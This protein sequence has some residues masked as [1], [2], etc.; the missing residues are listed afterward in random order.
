[1]NTRLPMTPGRVLAL[2]IG[3]PLALVVIGWTALTA[4]AYAGIG[5]YPV[6]LDLPVR[7]HTVAVAIDS[8]TMTV[9]QITGDRLRVTGTARYSLVRSTVTRRITPAGVTVSAGCHFVTGVC[10]FTAQVGLPAGVQASLSNA[11]GDMTLR[12]LASRVDVVAG[13]GDV[14]PYDLSGPVSIQ[15]NSGDVT[16]AGLSGPQVVVKSGSGDIVIGGLTSADV[17]ASNAS[18]DVVLTF[19]KVPDRVSVSASSGDVRLQLPPGP[20]S[21]QV[22][23]STS[24]GNRAVNVPVSSA[25]PH[26]IIVTDGS[27]D[28]SIT[29]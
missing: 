13:S 7:G 22:S 14:H 23:A 27:G 3:V 8:G 24:S 28:I 11:S 4:V 17:T 1:V 20:A 5:T 6:R 21:Y 2:V 9:G 10:S 16:G 18:G 19:T 25:S 15:D 29:N 12:A 26:R